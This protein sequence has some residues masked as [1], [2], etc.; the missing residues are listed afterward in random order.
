MDKKRRCGS[1]R[2]RKPWLREFI[3]ELLG[4]FVLI[5]I[6]NGS[7][8]QSTFSIGSKG[9]FFSVNWG[10]G[11]GVLLGVVVSGGVSGGHINPAV[12]VAVATL[13]K[14]PWRKV[15][16]YLA[17]QYLGSF[18]ASCVLFL[19]YWDALV[20][21]E[22]EVSAYR[23]TPDTAMIFT[24]FPRYHLT[25]IGGVTDQF[26]GTALLL[27][28]V[29][30]ITDRKNMQVSKQL[31]PLFIGLTVLAI[32]VSF[33][34]NC[35][36]AI[37][38]AR[39]FAPRI[40]TAISGWGLKVFTY[41]HWWLVPIFACHLGAIVG[42]WFYYLAIEMNWPKEDTEI[43]RSADEEGQLPLKHGLNGRDPPI[44]TY[45]QY[46]NSFP[47][48]QQG[49]VPAS[50]PDTLHHP[51]NFQLQDKEDVQQRTLPSKAAFH[52]ELK[53]KVNLSK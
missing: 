9:T 41:R 49:S 23:T 30:A 48:G 52:D 24:T 3:A 13:G 17:A 5:L 1:W 40:F 20:K 35:G 51:S 8:A 6:G 37:N 2:V 47:E 18:L 43:D 34:F 7:V 38:P 4:T 28:A 21:Y 36:Y 16:H 39:D 14:F 11:L 10:W 32:G 29:C 19:V 46:Q 33:G 31:V 50:A 22:H 15:P 12:T 45:I 27:V 42:A 53:S 26:F 44:P 25:W